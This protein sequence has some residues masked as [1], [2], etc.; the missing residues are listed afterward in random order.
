VLT[1][2]AKQMFGTNPIQGEIAGV[3]VIATHVPKHIIET[4]DFLFAETL[5]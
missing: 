2:E 1:E 3:S 4:A 5:R